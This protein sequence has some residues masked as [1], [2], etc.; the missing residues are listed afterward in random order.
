MTVTVCGSPYLICLALKTNSVYTFMM[1][2]EQIF[3]GAAVFDY[4]GNNTGITHFCN[5]GC[6]MSSTM[7]IDLGC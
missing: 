7:L 2:N 4:C 5:L 1:I 6:A 3:L